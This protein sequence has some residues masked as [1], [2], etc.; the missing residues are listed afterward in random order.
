MLFGTRTTAAVIL[1]AALI[2]PAAAN[3]AQP[4]NRTLVL[5]SHLPQALRGG[6][7]DG[8]MRLTLTPE[9]IISGT[10]QNADTGQISN[11]TGGVDSGNKLWLEVGGLG[12]YHFTG[13]LAG[14]TIDATAYHGN[15]DLRL[16]AQP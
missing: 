2:L 6:E 5:Q 9:G 7:I 1:A 14:T 12:H 4:A 16:L 10:Y 11:V 8:T 15:D 3:A 13:T